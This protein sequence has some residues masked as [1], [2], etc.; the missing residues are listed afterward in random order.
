M[1]VAQAGS[2]SVITLF[3][4]E[5][6]ALCLDSFGLTFETENTLFYHKKS[7]S[8][9]LKALTFKTIISTLSFKKLF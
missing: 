4:V 1:T 9:K 6:E 7:G 2:S 8:G 5:D 3:F